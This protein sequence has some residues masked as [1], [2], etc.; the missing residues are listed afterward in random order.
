M[1]KTV[2]AEYYSEQYK[3]S[4]NTRNSLQFS[5]N[6]KT[7]LTGLYDTWKLPDSDK[8][9][10][11]VKWVEVKARLREPHTRFLIVIHINDERVTTLT[12]ADEMLFGENVKILFTTRIKLLP[13]CEKIEILALSRDEMIEVFVNNT[14]ESGGDRDR[15]KKEIADNPGIFDKITDD[16]YRSN[17]ML[18]A[19]SARIKYAEN[20]T[21]SELYEV[22]KKDPLAHSKVTDIDFTKETSLASLT[23]AGH[24]KNLY[25]ISKLSEEQV[26]FLRNMSLMDYEGVPLEKFNQWMKLDNNN[27][28]MSLEKN[29][30]IKVKQSDDN[31]KIIYMHP[32]VSDA[33]FEQTRAN[34]KTC[35]NF[36][37]QIYNVET[38]YEKSI[39]KL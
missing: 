14:A 20:L 17:T 25:D 11:D 29:G 7:T 15:I 5:G 26:D 38:N 34:S 19:L 35:R 2:T 4:Y 10:A 36:L 9:T 21:L 37:A 6:I 16:I 27:T 18:V 32:A 23:L 30:F 24:I 31:K 3:D 22:V 28:E 12:D 39:D 1:G 8:K 33:V 13:R